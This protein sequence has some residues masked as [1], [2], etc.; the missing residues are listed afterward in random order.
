MV[1]H[2]EVEA[3]VAQHLPPP[4]AH[5]RQ[6]DIGGEVVHHLQHLPARP[7]FRLNAADNARLKLGIPALTRGRGERQT[8]Q[9]RHSPP[10]GGGGTADLP[11]QGGCISC[12]FGTTSGVQGGCSL[13]QIV[14]QAKSQS[15][16]S[17]SQKLCGPSIKMH[18]GDLMKSPIRP[19]TPFLA[20]I[21]SEEVSSTARCSIPLTPGEKTQSGQGVASLP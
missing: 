6:V 9:I 14:D 18:V 5:R 15:E 3:A 2:P 19:R 4:P 11:N 16:V 1:L 17:R 12:M 21:G 10:G 8:C 13:L 20:R 7:G